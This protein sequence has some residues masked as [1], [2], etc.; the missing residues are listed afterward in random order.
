MRESSRVIVIDKKKILLIHRIK[1]D[2]EY[3]VLPGGGIEPGETPEEAAL[4]ELKEETS[5]DGEVVFLWK[6]EEEYN[7]NLTHYFLAKTFKGNL[8]LG[9]PEV[10]TVSAENQ[11]LL[12]WIP[13]AKISKLL[14][15]PQ[16]LKERLIKEIVRSCKNEPELS[17]EAIEA[18]E[19]ARERMRKG[20][21]LTE[22][23]ARKRLGL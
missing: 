13:L 8:M 6:F 17:K 18:I 15:Y 14:L 3:Y 21:F 7:H 9:G 5:L 11:Y 2:K 16:E 12:E 10:E 23:E 4:R 1:G 20:K 19:K 22:A